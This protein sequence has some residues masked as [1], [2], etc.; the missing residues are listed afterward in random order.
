MASIDLFTTDNLLRYISEWDPREPAHTKG[1]Y[2]D[3]E[4]K[5]PNVEG[6]LR[7]EIQTYPAEDVDK[8]VANVHPCLLHVVRIGKGKRE[9]EL[10]PVPTYYHWK[11]VFE[12]EDGIVKII[13]RKSELDVEKDGFTPRPVPEIDEITKV[14]GNSIVLGRK[15]GQLNL[16]LLQPKQQARAKQTE[17]TVTKVLA[18]RLQK[19][20]EKIEMYEQFFKKKNA[21][22]LKR[23]RLRVDFYKENGTH[24]GYSISPQTI[25]D[26]GNKE[27][28]SM[29]FYDATPH[30]SCIRGGRKIIMV[31]EYNLAKDVSPIF[32]VYD[33]FGEPRPELDQFLSQ[34]TDFNRRNQT[35][36]F[37]TPPQPRLH[38]ITENLNNWTIKLLAKRKGDGYKS[39]KMFNFRYIDHEFNSCPFCDYKVDSDELVKIEAGIEGPKPRQK[40]RIMTCTPV[41]CT[42]KRQRIQSTDEQSC[43]SSETS[44]YLKSSP[45]YSMSSSYE[46]PVNTPDSGIDI[47]FNGYNSDGGYTSNSD[48]EYTTTLTQEDL[49]N[50]SAMTEQAKFVVVEE[51]AQFPKAYVTGAQFQNMNQPLVQNVGV[52]SMME[53]P[54]LNFES[55]WGPEELTG[56]AEDLIEN[57]D[58][59]QLL[60]TMDIH[61]DICTPQPAEISNIGSS[62]FTAPSVAPANAFMTQK[63][64]W[65]SQGTM[66]FIKQGPVLLQQRIQSDSTIQSDNAKPTEEEDVLRT[67]SEVCKRKQGKSKKDKT[68]I[69]Q[70]Q[71]ERKQKPV[72]ESLFIE[73]LPLL[74]MIFMALIIIFKLIGEATVE[75]P[76]FAVIASS[77]AT[78]IFMIFMKNKFFT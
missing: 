57:I 70:K 1:G 73:D 27:I 34:P 63:D 64:P 49:N 52:R 9:Q 32:E 23:V 37:I 24:C 15:R 58:V 54:S 46:M 61:E 21:K 7:M 68:H 31:S 2:M 12:I 40:K 72:P 55:H 60:I 22:N 5:I 16:I 71:T 30:K 10:E 66:P 8:L 62:F 26:T 33:D 67:A 48:L 39:N 47:P 76:Q 29:D 78:A 65:M 53:I 18:D 25:V 74:T 56:T 19:G 75:M 43:G 20:K 28:G 35:I 77:M 42:E 50:L 36:I 6:K 38:E 45:A 4:I 11:Q 59:D 13:N 44:S 69:D 17:A 14:D 51:D 3:G 41:V